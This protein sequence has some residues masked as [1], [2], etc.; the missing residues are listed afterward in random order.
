MT[1]AGIAG[2][3]GIDAARLAVV[4]RVQRI[5]EREVIAVR[6]V[7]AQI[8]GRCGPQVHGAGLQN[9]A[10][11]AYRTACHRRASRRNASVVCDLDPV[12]HLVQQRGFAA[13]ASGSRTL[14]SGRC[15][16]KLRELMS[17]ASIE[18]PAQCADVAH[19]HGHFPADVSRH[20]HRQIL[21]VR[22]HVVGSKAVRATLR[23][24]RESA[25]SAGTGRAP[26]RCCCDVCQVDVF[27]C[28]ARR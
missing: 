19:V 9:A 26:A 23:E 18:L 13:G 16:G 11:V 6:Q 8:A 5:G 27:Q 2:K 25:A 15:R 20:R 17:I 28:R 4:Q 21:N 24:S 10:V 14:L 1:P 12:E 22:G 7:V 3:C